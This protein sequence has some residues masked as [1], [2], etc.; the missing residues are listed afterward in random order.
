MHNK[1]RAY[2]LQDAGADTVEANRLL[3]FPA[4]MRRYGIG[5]Q[6]LVDLG[7]RRIRLLTNNPSKRV[8]LEAYGLS[9]VERVPLV[10][11]INP[12]N[13]LYMRTKREKLGHLFEESQVRT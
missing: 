8:G 2:A 6:I 3:G 13:E 1:V 11:P 12:E 5:A 9:V 4:D 7:L 10:A